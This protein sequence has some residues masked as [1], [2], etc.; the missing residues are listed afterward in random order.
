MASFGIGI[1]IYYK[2]CNSACVG[3]NPDNA[4]F[5]GTAMF[6]ANENMNIHTSFFNSVKL[7]NN[8]KHRQ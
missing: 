2:L 6:S 3:V 1:Y 7:L 4:I 8:Y 5:H